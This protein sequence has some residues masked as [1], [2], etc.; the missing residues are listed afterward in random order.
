MYEYICTYNMQLESTIY[1]F[2][3]QQQ[4]LRTLKNT[5]KFVTLVMIFRVLPIKMVL[6]SLHFEVPFIPKKWQIKKIKRTKL[7]W[8]IRELKQSTITEVETA[9]YS[10]VSG[11]KVGRGGSYHQ[12]YQGLKVFL[13]THGT[14]NRELCETEIW[15]GVPQTWN[16][17]GKE[18]KKAATWAIIFS[19]VTKY[20]PFSRH[21][22]WK[23]LL[24][25]LYKD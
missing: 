21:E 2:T 10:C 15:G 1:I 22:E 13:W 14:E 5:T 11:P 19:I 18:N 23:Q 12:Q 16:R 8:K 24:S 4:P 20:V 3:F 9:C 6:P 25:L 7:W 17:L